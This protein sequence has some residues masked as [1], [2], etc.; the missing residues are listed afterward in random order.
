M[1]S[2][3]AEIAELLRLMPNVEAPSDVRAAWFERKAQLFERIAEAGGPDAA[4][5]HRLA[6]G[7]HVRATRIRLRAG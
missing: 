4:D 7:A 5:A 6:L 1:R 2:T 3:A